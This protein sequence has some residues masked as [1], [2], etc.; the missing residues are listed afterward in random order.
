M[1]F[2]IGGNFGPSLESV[3]PRS[4]TS[5]VRA[6]DGAGWIDTYRSIHNSPDL[7]GRPTWPSDQGTVAVTRIDG[8]LVFGASSDTPVYEKIDR[9][10]A[11]EWRE[12][13]I[14]GYPKVMRSDNIGY[15]PNDAIFHAEATV[16]IRA[17]NENA[18]S[19]AGKT[20]EVHTD[21]DMCYTSCRKV[22]PFLGLELGNPTVTFVGRSGV[23]RTMLNG[24]WQE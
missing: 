5:N 1:R 21:R 23:R 24:R 20:L 4:P 16:L 6:F 12:R 3:P 13:L 15:K 11:S 9:V 19:L 18:G 10:A 22:L 8:R 14:S 7:F 2:G 17:A